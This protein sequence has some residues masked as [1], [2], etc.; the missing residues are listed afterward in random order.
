M[1]STADNPAVLLL[2]D[3]EL[4]AVATLL[5][6]SG[7]PYQR[8]RSAEIPEDLDPPVRLLIAT[9]RHASKLRPNPP[10]GAPIRIVATEEDSPSLR[11]M[12]RA[13]GFSLLVRRAAHA[14]V[15]RLLI[16]RVLFEGD[17]RRREARLPLGAQINVEHPGGA[18]RQAPRPCLLVDISNRGCHFVASEPF[19]LGAAVHF[20]LSANATGREPLRLAGVIV[21]TGPWTREDPGRHSCA[22]IFADD[23]EEASRMG[24]ARMINARIRGPLS[25]APAPQEGLALP[26]SNSPALAGLQLDDETDPPVKTDIQVDLEFAAKH[27]DSGDRRKQRRANYQQRIEVANPNETSVLM[28]RDLSAGGMRVE[29]FADAEVGAHL[30]LALYGPCEST[31]LQIDAEIVRDDGED[32][33]AL[34]FCNLPREIAQQLES[35]VACLPDVESLELGEA[36][37]L[38]NILTEV[39]SGTPDDEAR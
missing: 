8:L 17:E 35:F 19:P 2:D 24:L 32:G 29:R 33:I 16:Q 34:R 25:L 14:A 6:R 9:P 1:Q 28:G 37:S 27:F 10:G 4:D 36:K 22:M 23:L 12:M 38:G 30:A 39:L 31:P 5:E 15:W 13:R 11:R 18:A 26:A 20:E 21:R 3:G 7:L